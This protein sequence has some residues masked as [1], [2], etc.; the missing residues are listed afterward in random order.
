MAVFTTNFI[1]TD[2]LGQM[3]KGLIKCE[4]FLG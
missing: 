2:Q 4:I 3:L 1:K